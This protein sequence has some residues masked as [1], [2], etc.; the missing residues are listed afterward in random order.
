MSDR[1]DAA[2]NAVE[3]PGRDA[4]LDH[5]GAQAKRAK[6]TACND[7]VLPLGEFGDLPIGWAVFC[8]YSALKTAHLV[9]RGHDGT[10]RRAWV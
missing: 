1:V 7:T 3:A 9:H 10:Q 8:S 5:A 2:V 6:L 4:A